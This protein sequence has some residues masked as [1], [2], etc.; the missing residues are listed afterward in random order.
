MVLENAM[1]N[2]L[3]IRGMANELANLL[4]ERLFEGVTGDCVFI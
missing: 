2:G 1:N 4:D 3:G